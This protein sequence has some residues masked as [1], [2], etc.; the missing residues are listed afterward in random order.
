LYFRLF[1]RGLSFEE[2]SFEPFAGAPDFV[3]VYENN[4][5]I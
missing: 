4:L 5:G 2:K 3:K 1:K